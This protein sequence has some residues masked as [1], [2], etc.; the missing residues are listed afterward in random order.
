MQP[1]RIYPIRQIPFRNPAISGTGTNKRIRQT[2]LPQ[3]DPFQDHRNCTSTYFCCQSIQNTLTVF[4]VNVLLCQS[5]STWQAVHCRPCLLHGKQCIPVWFGTW[6]AGP[7]HTGFANWRACPDGYS[8]LCK[9]CTYPDLRQFL[10][11]LVGNTSQTQKSHK[12]ELR[13]FAKRFFFSKHISIHTQ[14]LSKREFKIRQRTGLMFFQKTIDFLFIISGIRIRI[15]SS[16]SFLLFVLPMQSTGLISRW[17]SW[18]C[19]LQSSSPCSS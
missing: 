4:G 6:Q 10:H 19:R 8:V 7:A 18:W 3:N 1:Y 12:C 2:W 13:V 15:D 9:Q 11:R 5:F 17:R 14:G 16:Y